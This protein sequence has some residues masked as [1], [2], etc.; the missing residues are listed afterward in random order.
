MSNIKTKMSE[1]EM[2]TMNDTE[3]RE[4]NRERSSIR[5]QVI[6]HMMADLEVIRERELEE[7]AQQNAT[8]PKVRVKPHVRSPEYSPDTAEEDK[9]HNKDTIILAE[10]GDRFMK[11]WDSFIRNENETFKFISET[12]ARMIALRKMKKISP[13]KSKLIEK[14]K[15]MQKSIGDEKKSSQSIPNYRKKPTSPTPNRQRTKGKSATNACKTKRGDDHSA[16]EPFEAVRSPSG[17]LYEDA[18]T[19]Q[20]LSSSEVTDLSWDGYVPDVGGEDRELGT[21]T[22]ME[23][24]VQMTSTS[25]TKVARIEIEQEEEIEDVKE[26]EEKDIQHCQSPVICYKRPKLQENN[27]EAIVVVEPVFDEIVELHSDVVDQ[28]Q[29][30]TSPATRSMTGQLHSANDKQPNERISISGQKDNDHSNTVD[31]TQNNVPTL[32]NEYDTCKSNSVL[33]EESGVF[34]NSEMDN[35]TGKVLS[36]QPNKIK[37]APLIIHNKINFVIRNKLMF[38]KKEMAK[39]QM[40]KEREDLERNDTPMNDAPDSDSENQGTG[41]PQPTN[42]LYGRTVKSTLSTVDI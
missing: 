33:S 36:T 28:N 20:S 19:R 41:E 15:S 37:E 9:L 12:I 26:A 8:V 5:H 13:E 35:T 10:D 7:E 29:H 17:L 42:A 4:Y 32:V 11:I 25:E 18:R 14:V 38:K 30:V 24:V 22:V 16:E 23:G 27:P 2:I 6:D 34:Y 21:D 40:I 39:K 1:Y 31:D 3:I